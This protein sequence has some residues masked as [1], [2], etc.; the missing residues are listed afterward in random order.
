MR[1]VL[2]VGGPM[3]GRRLQVADYQPT[4][5]VGAPIDHA[6]DIREPFDAMKT[7]IPTVEYRISMFRGDQGKYACWIATPAADPRDPMQI[8]FE[9]YKNR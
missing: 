1:T 4:V 9:S 2:M 7:P 8:L 5:V 6:R 3:D